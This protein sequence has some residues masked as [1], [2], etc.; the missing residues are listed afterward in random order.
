MPNVSLEVLF[1]LFGMFLVII[2]LAGG[3]RVKVISIEVGP[4][5]STWRLAAII[6]GLIVMAAV[7]WVVLSKGVDEGAVAGPSARPERHPAGGFTGHVRPYMLR[8]ER[9]DRREETPQ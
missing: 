2:G 3:Q 1:A 6:L 9:R 5:Q 8:G 4:L 7:G